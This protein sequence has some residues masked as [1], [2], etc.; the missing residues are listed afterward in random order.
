MN[1]NPELSSAPKA[2]NADLNELLRFAT[3][4]AQGEHIE[5]VDYL[6]RKNPQ[7][8]LASRLTREPGARPFVHWSHIDGPLLVCSDGSCHWLA[9]GE[10]IGHRWGFVSLEA[11]EKKY[12]P[13]PVMD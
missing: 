10:R 5:P 7:L 11:L 13:R 4:A 6:V 8:A 12:N 2:S 1:P 9:L 3:R